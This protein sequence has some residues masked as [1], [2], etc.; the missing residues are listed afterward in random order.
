M[1]LWVKSYGI[2]QLF[3]SL[4]MYL[5]YFSPSAYNETIIKPDF[6]ASVDGWFHRDEPMYTFLY[7]LTE[8]L[9]GHVLYNLQCCQCCFV[10]MCYVQLLQMSYVCVFFSIFHPHIS[11]VSTGHLSIGSTTG[12]VFDRKPCASSNK[13]APSRSDSKLWCSILST[14]SAPGCGIIPGNWASWCIP[15]LED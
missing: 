8:V 15:V 14:G 1:W 12:P 4:P 2:Y 10:M 5:W 3:W 6:L 7:R 11:E 13:F 9:T